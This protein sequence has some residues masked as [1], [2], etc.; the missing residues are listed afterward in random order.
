MVFWIFENQAVPAFTIHFRPVREK[1][2]RKLGQTGLLRDFDLLGWLV[3]M[4][5]KH[6]YFDIIRPD[7]V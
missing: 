2:V 1:N 3:C 4:V 7:M 5:I 6:G